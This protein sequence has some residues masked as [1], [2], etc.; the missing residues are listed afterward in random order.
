MGGSC[1]GEGAQELNWHVGVV[2]GGLVGLPQ[3]RSH[4]QKYFLKL[5]KA[6]NALEVPPPRPK[7]RPSLTTTSLLPSQDGSP[8]LALRRTTR[9]PKAT[10][11]T[12]LR[13]LP[14]VLPADNGQN[15][16]T[17]GEAVDAGQA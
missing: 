10:K 4:A 12:P 6:G 17:E 1:K 11:R 7:K 3:V 15:G 9:Q 13:V 14:R 8:C 2:R 16:S 5:E